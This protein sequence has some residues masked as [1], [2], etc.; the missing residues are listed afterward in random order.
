[1]TMKN[2]LAALTLLAALPCAAQNYPDKPV[3]LVVPYATGA[4]P[5]IVA[6]LVGG[7]LGD[8]M[9][10]RV[11]IDNRVGASG[12]VAT[13]AVVKSAPDGY[14]LI[15][16][17]NNHTT[18]PFV[19]KDLPYDRFSDLAPVSLWVKG[20]LVLA[21]SQKS[22]LN[23]LQE[24]VKHAK[25]RPGAINFAISGAGSP[26]RLLMELLKSDAG[27]DVTTVP[28]KSTATALSELVA[29]GVDAIFATVPSVSS[30]YK[31]GRIRVLGVTSESR[32]SFVPGVPAINEVY[33]GFAGEAWMGLLA[34]AKTPSAII[35]RL[36]SESSKVLAQADAKA[37]LAELGMDTAGGTPAEFDR[38]LRTESERWSKVIREQNLNL[39]E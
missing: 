31:S 10:Q 28:Y 24:F 26:G 4:F 22:G 11:V 8:A 19:F 39:Q 32:T 18:N 21:V 20:P 33:P 9:G 34:P 3:R 12:T 38:Y 2:T 15:G 17:I 25:A 13:A 16:V 14:T 35:G 23:S 37:R 27:I 5:D 29:G 7:K 1:M 30:H 6:R 36:N